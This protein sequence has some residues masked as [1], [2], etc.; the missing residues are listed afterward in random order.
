MP[1]VLRS[2]RHARQGRAGVCRETSAKKKYRQLLANF[3]D[4]SG[5]CRPPSVRL[6]HIFNVALCRMRKRKRMPRLPLFG[7]SE[8]VALDDCFGLTELHLRAVHNDQA[9][10]RSRRCG[11]LLPPSEHSHAARS[12]SA[13]GRADQVIHAHQS[14][15]LHLRRHPELAAKKAASFAIRNARV[16]CRRLMFVAP[17]V[18]RN[19]RS[20]LEITKFRH[21]DSRV[22]CPAACASPKKTACSRY[23]PA[24]LC[25]RHHLARGVHELSNLEQFTCLQADL[26]MVA[27]LWS[28]RGLCP[29]RLSMSDASTT[30]H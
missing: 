9:T 5:G 21:R 13:L 20:I 2:P 3:A 10:R 29:P 28:T 27:V 26:A 1:K 17:P 11:G 25:R 22:I 6:L 23:P 15:G 16:G 4:P 18:R 12:R 8:E 19:D 30:K 7:H 14:F 24:M